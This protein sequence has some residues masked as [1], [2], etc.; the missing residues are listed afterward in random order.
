MTTT[1]LRPEVPRTVLAALIGMISMLF[2]AFTAAYLERRAS[3]RDW[4]RVALPALIWANTGL[5]AISSATLE[6]ARRT[7][8]RSWL[9][10]TT[11]LALLF[12]AGQFVAWRQ[13]TDQGVYLPTH[14]HS[15]F[16][17][18]LT[19][20][21]GVHLAGGLVALLLA[22]SRPDRLPLCAAFWHF[23]GVVWVYILAVLHFL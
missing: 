11:G 13:L 7:G 22:R 3:T 23:L 1:T 8:R 14:P 6:V 2:L 21:H 15:A 12:F 17:Y 5:L 10:L 4:V 16:F 18:M 9:D 19:A 20:V